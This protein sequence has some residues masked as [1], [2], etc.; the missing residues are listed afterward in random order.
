M[1]GCLA[2]VPIVEDKNG[3]RRCSLAHYDPMGLA[4]ELEREKHIKFPTIMGLFNKTA[5]VS[6]SDLIRTTVIIMSTDPNG[7]QAKFIKA[8]KTEAR[9]ILGCKRVQVIDYRGVGSESLT[10]NLPN[11]SSGNPKYSTNSV[12]NKP[13]EW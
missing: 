1:G 10:I 3:D 12:K 7:Q 5:K 11:S 13:I 2:I 4:L 8:I 6:S 9:Y